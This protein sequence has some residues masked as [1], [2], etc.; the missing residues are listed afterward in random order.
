MKTTRFNHWLCVV[1]AAGSMLTSRAATVRLEDL[2]LKSMSSGWGQPRKNL[3]VTQ[4]PLMI[5]GL[6]FS[7]GIGT[8]AES[9]FAVVLDGRARTFSAKVGVDDGA[10]KAGAGLEFVVY[11]DDRELWRSGVCRLGEKPRECRLTLAGVTNLELV[12]T[13]TGK[14]SD[15]C[16]AD[17]VEGVFEFDGQPP[18]AASVASEKEEAV[19]LTPPAPPEPRLN[20]PGVYGVRPGSPFLYRVPCTGKRPLTFSASGLPEG[21]A[22][23]ASSGIITGRVAKAG[24]YQVVLNAQNS[25]ARAQRDFVIVAGDRLALTP[26]M[27]W[28]SWYIHYD[29][30]SDAVMRQAASQ[31]IDTGMAD[32]G[33]QYVNIDDCWMKKKGD[34]PYRDSAGAVLPNAKFPD[35]KSLA[36]FIHSRGLKA[37]LYTSPGPWTCGGY[38][39]AY[40]HEQA[41]AHKFAEWGYDFLK[42]DWCS[43]GGVAKG[44]G[45]VRLRQ[46]YQ[47]MW[48]ELQ[49]LDRDIAFN[50]CQYG[51]GDVWKWGGTVGNCWRTT[52]DL[53][54]ESDSRLPGFYKI[55]FSNA[56]HWENAGPGAWN[57][58]DYILI[59]WVGD[60][61]AMGPGKPT[62]LTPSEQYSYMSMW[63]LMAAPLIFSGDMARLDPFTLNVLCNAEV[64]A[65]DQD[66]LG[67]QARVASHTRNEI[68]LVKELED[69]SKA[70]GL[71][72][73]GSASRK[74]SASWSSLEISGKQRVRDLWRQKEIGLREGSFE[75]E[76]PRHGVALVRLQP[77]DKKK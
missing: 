5:G 25:L 1:A 52:G 16:H 11:S 3:S 26:P 33:Y 47:V 19:L 43:Y 30:V 23:E 73:L 53:G 45:L 40:Q 46:P 57:D 10:S 68:I 63:C 41:D 6:Q 66:S 4:K 20:G 42:Y 21:L 60:A 39:G 75:A 51:M 37:G 27:G 14:S 49:K 22:L 31:M 59:G 9:E 54:L 7:N 76:V 61:N 32:Y 44:N 34:E 72:N 67:R 64:I 36:D 65:V 38:V 35:M 28:N 77:D 24:R 29:R 74:L 56:A 50:L 12:V 55:G 18:L 62:A 8:H 71:F 69:G 15:Y 70:V 48:T 17:W 58:P 2:D 13:T